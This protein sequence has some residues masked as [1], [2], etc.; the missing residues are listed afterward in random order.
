[1]S[2]V[3]RTVRERRKSQGRRSLGGVAQAWTRCPVRH[4]TGSGVRR[5]RMGSPGSYEASTSRST[6]AAALFQS[7]AA[8]QEDTRPGRNDEGRNVLTV[9]IAES[10]ADWALECAESTSRPS[11]SWWRPAC[12]ISARS[13][14]PSRRRRFRGLPPKEVDDNDGGTAS[15]G[16]SLHL[17]LRASSWSCWGVRHAI[18]RQ[19]GRPRD[20]STTAG[21]AWLGSSGW[22]ERHVGRR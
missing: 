8:W 3:Y 18:T 15:P 19:N 17:W 9:E 20:G 6:A 1:M 22:M 11:A 12:L 10:Y 2:A 7:N 4:R 21:L 5:F 14:C 16:G 13:T